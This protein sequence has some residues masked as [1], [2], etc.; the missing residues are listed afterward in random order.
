MYV[1][2]N[3]RAYLAILARDRGLSSLYVA[4]PLLQIKFALFADTPVPN[5]ICA[6]FEGQ[7]LKSFSFQ[8]LPISLQDYIVYVNANRVSRVST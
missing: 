1:R 5:S 8:A 6:A 3:R 4:R 7:I 2:R